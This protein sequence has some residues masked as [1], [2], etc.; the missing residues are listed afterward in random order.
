[1]VDVLVAAS[2]HTVASGRAAVVIVQEVR[3]RE[4]LILYVHGDNEQ[5]ANAVKVADLLCGAPRGR[6]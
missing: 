3:G 1:M 2:G 4:S 6:W 5:P